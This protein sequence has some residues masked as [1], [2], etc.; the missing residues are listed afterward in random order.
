MLAHRLQAEFRIGS[1]ALYRFQDCATPMCDLSATNHDNKKVM[2]KPTTLTTYEFLHTHPYQYCLLCLIIITSHHLLRSFHTRGK[3]ITLPHHL[4]HSNQ[5]LT[6]TKNR[7]ISHLPFIR[8]FGF[9]G[10]FRFFEFFW[11]FFFG[12]FQKR[13]KTPKKSLQCY[14]APPIHY[15]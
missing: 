11:V 5:P 6:L 2:H 10:L 15:I 1:F 9:L 4:S 7:S 12:F 8:F 14:H 3:N 13:A